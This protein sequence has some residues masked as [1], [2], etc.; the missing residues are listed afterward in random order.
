MASHQS[1]TTA[2]Y[3]C[4]PVLPAHHTHIYCV[5]TFLQLVRTTCYIQI[6]PTADLD[7]EAPSI[8]YISSSIN[9]L[10]G[11]EQ[12]FRN[13]KCITTGRYTKHITTLI[14]C[15]WRKGHDDDIHHYTS[16]IPTTR[17]RLRNQPIFRSRPIFVLASADSGC[18]W[19]DDYYYAVVQL[20]LLL[21]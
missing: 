13:R 21:D 16:N 8:L 3:V 18:L 6:C 2:I 17:T 11:R 20:G 5:T 12:T 4:A 14:M 9:V 10:Y 15:P 19:V 7:A 1:S